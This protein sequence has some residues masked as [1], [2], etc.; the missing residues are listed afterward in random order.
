MIK[1]FEY[2]FGELGIT[3]RDIEAILG[4]EEVTLPEPFP[5]L[6]EQGLTEAPFYTEIKGGYRIFE[7]IFIDTINNSLR[8]D[9]TIFHPSKI[10][11]T[12]FKKASSLVL[13]VCTAGAEIT[14]YSKNIAQKGDPLLAYIFDVI[15]SLT[16]EK[17]MEKIDKILEKETSK[18]GLTISDR[19]SPGYCEWNVA[20]QQDLFRL[21]PENFCGISLSSSSLMSPVK[22]VSGIIGIGKNL[23]KTGYQCHW[24]TDKNCIYGKIKRQKKN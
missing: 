4:F 24:C 3:A 8:I 17:A 7:A 12:Q 5:E 21:L 22:S 19:F 16:V 15:G 14:N 11:V 23:K 1:E 13:F 20:E 10:V 9:E 18:K 2:T 6:I